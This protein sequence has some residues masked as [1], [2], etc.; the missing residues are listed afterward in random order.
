MAGEPPVA[1]LAVY[2]SQAVAFAGAPLLDSAEVIAQ[3]LAVVHL[4][5]SASSSSNSFFRVSMAPS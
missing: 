2:R 5:C 3:A 4:R 1:H